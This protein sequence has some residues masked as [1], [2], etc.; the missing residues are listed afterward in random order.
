MAQEGSNEVGTKIAELQG[1]IRFFNPT[2]QVEAVNGQLEI[3]AATIVW[4][5]WCPRPGGGG[6]PGHGIRRWMRCAVAVGND[7]DYGA[8]GSNPG[9]GELDRPTTRTDWPK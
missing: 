6:A 5:G 3:R 7:S 4:T 2:N 9:F 1:G 8:S